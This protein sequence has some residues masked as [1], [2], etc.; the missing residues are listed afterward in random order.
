MKPTSKNVNLKSKN[1]L[2]YILFF[3]LFHHF[4]I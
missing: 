2:F 1:I 3:I 4:I